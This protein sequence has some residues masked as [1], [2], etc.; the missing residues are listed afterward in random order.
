MEALGVA[1]QSHVLKLRGSCELSSICKIPSGSLKPRCPGKQSKHEQP[2]AGLEVA[3][4]GGST[5]VADH[6]LPSRGH[7]L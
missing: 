2:W 6:R 1:K 4:L 3:T 5:L 7:L